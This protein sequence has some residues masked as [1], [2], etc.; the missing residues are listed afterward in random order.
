MGGGGT[1]EGEEIKG[2]GRGD[3]VGGG[4][5][6]LVGDRQAG[7]EEGVRERG[8]GVGGRVKREGGRQAGEK[9]GRRGV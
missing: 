2:S 4:G 9:D 6:K 1:R 5:A 8:V 3:T 7:Q